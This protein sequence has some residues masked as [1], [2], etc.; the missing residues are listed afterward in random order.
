[1]FMWS[2]FLQRVGLVFP[3]VNSSPESAESWS[4]VQLSVP[5]NSIHVY[6]VEPSREL[7][8]CDRHVGTLLVHFPRLSLGILGSQAVEATPGIYRQPL[9][10]RALPRPGL[11]GNACCLPHSHR[12]KPHDIDPV[13]ATESGERNVGWPRVWG[14]VIGRRPRRLETVSWGPGGRVG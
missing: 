5:R 6:T 11:R 10:W 12:L 9:K 3:L 4:L 13:R 7:P 2:C 8:R 1:M 14:P